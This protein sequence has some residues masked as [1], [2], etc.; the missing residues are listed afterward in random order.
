MTDIVRYRW[1]ARKSPAT[2]KRRH[3]FVEG[4]ALSLCWNASRMGEADIWKPDPER[5]QCWQCA[6]ELAKAKE[7][8]ALQEAGW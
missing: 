3:V 7:R 5:E 4:S 1:L 2:I 6:D 8:S